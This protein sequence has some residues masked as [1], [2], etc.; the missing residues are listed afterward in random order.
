[1]FNHSSNYT[2]LL[3]ILLFSCTSGKYNDVPTYDATCK[4]FENSI[5]VDGFVEPVQTASISCPPNIDGTIIRLIEDGTFVHAGDTVCIIEFQDLQNAYD[6]TLIDLENTTADFNKTK[7]N[8][9][10]QYAILEAQVEDNNANTQIAQLDSLQ[11]AYSPPNIRR[12][13]ELE[14]EKVAIQKA[15]LDNKL[16]SLDI[17]NKSEIRRWE[18]RIQR[19]NNRIKDLKKRL[20]ALVLKAP[21]D[22]LAMIAINR[23]TGVKHKIGDNVW[24]NMLII[25]MPEYS[26]MKVRISASET[27]YKYINLDDSVVYTFDAMPKN[28]AWGK[29]K[30]K[31]PIGT[32]YK[33]GSKVKVFDVEASV[34]SVL[35]MPSPGFT[36]NCRII[37]KEVKDTLVVPQVCVFEEDSMKVAYVKNKN[38]FEMRQIALGPSSSK[39]VIITSGLK[40]KEKIALIKPVNAL[41]NNRI[42]LKKGEENAEDKTNLNQ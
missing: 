42:L 30:K 12:M 23:M 41:I 25:S 39:E 7:A 13:K 1:M 26:E 40:E 38:G 11:L 10:L 18:L 17:I 5:T 29:I 35:L 2:Y 27:E 32:P 36:A 4:N 33:N 6:N 24:D 8:L 3:V 19:I 31:S 37:M 16:Q 20:D 14:L 22:G 34:D 28:K 9:T 15:Q 21:K